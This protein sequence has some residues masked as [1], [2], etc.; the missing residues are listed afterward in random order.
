M[1]AAAAVTAS[2]DP[3]FELSS[4]WE[5]V[6]SRAPRMA[7]TM[8]AYLEWLSGRLHRRCR[9]CLLPGGAEVSPPRKGRSCST[10]GTHL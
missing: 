4:G 5:Q 10:S 1:S 7:T 9:S 8:S 2:P 6:E 3:T